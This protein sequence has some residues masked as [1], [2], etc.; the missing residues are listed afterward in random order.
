MVSQYSVPSLVDTI[1]ILVQSSTGTPFPLGVD[2]SFD[3]VV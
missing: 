3:L 1:V 2:V